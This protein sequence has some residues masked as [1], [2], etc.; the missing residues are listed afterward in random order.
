MFQLLS[1]QDQLVEDFKGK[2]RKVYTIH[3]RLI[4]QRMRTISF[5][6]ILYL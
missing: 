1:N 2:K 4:M 5:F 6:K 3:A